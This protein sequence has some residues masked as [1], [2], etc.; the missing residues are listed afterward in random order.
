MKQVFQEMLQQDILN[1]DFYYNSKVPFSV[2][3][4]CG[5]LDAWD[6]EFLSSHGTHVS[7]VVAR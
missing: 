3:Y 6:G 2:D 7:G 5:D 4:A 1:G